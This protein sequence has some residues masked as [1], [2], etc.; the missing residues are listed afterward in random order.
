MMIKEKRSKNTK[1]RE[2]ADKKIKR[3]KT[4]DK[5]INKRRTEVMRGR[6]TN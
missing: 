4:K 6:M 5:T 3:V 1:S 2:S